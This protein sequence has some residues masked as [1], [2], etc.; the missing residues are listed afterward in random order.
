M[1]YMGHLPEA[2]HSPCHSGDG[3]RCEPLCDT[4]TGHWL[5]ASHDICHSGPLVPHVMHANMVRGLSQHMSFSEESFQ[6]LHD[7]CQKLVTGWRLYRVHV[8]SQLVEVSH[9]KAVRSSSC[10]VKFTQSI[11]LVLRVAHVN[12][13]KGVPGSTWHVSLPMAMSFLEQ[14]V[15][16]SSSRYVSFMGH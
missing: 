16:R 5:K 12:H 1:L 2:S 4:C 3:A 9:G 10:Y 14:W 11:G 7:T 6:D 13:D 15:V 8:S